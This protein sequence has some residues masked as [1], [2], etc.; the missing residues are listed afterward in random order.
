[1]RT[2]EIIRP[3]MKVP[4][5]LMQ[6]SF[7]R[8]YWFQLR[9]LFQAHLVQQLHRVR[10]ERQVGQDIQMRQC[11]PDHGHLEIHAELA[12]DTA[13]VVEDMPVYREGQQSESAL[14]AQVEIFR[15]ERGSLDAHAVIPVGEHMSDPMPGALS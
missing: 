5:L 3:S 1:M 12:G 2:G 11:S 7:K 10:A 8:P 13:H 4:V 6:S 15:Y 9:V 14:E